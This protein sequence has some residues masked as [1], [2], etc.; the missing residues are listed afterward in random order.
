[1]QKKPSVPRV[2]AD[3]RRHSLRSFLDVRGFSHVQLSTPPPAL[4]T[5]N[6]A[7]IAWTGMEMY[8]A[9]WQSELSCRALRTWSIDSGAV[10]GGISGVDGW[11]FRK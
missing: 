6:A 1:M 11:K 10:D 9:G 3:M 8:E 5:D 7:M 4:C 2:P